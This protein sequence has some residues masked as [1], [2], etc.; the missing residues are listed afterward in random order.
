MLQS[1]HRRGKNKST[2]SPQQEV[3]LT[4]FIN[5]LEVVHHKNKPCQTIRNS[6]AWSCL[7]ALG[8]LCCAN[9]RNCG[10]HNLGS[11]IMIMHPSVLQTWMR[12]SPPYATSMQYVRPPNPQCDFWPFP[13]M[14]MPLKE[15]DLRKRVKRSSPA[16][17]DYE[18]YLPEV[19]AITEETTSKG[20]QVLYLLI[21]ECFSANQRL[22]TSWTHLVKYWY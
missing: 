9:D 7:D 12:L 2:T 6:T 1:S 19:C 16:H 14:K 11:S 21:N 3:T 4:I 22:D 5:Y 20:L 10:W 15:P 13:Y 18:T 17:Q 8:M